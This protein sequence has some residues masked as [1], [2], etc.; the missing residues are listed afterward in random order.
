MGPELI[1]EGAALVSDG[2][3][4]GLSEFW[5]AST[6]VKYLVETVGHEA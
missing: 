4:H 1:A 3:T 2:K 6:R 5:E